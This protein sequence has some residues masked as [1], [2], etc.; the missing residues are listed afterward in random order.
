MHDEFWEEANQRVADFAEKAREG[1]KKYK[2]EDKVQKSRMAKSALVAMK[3][4]VEENFEHLEN[5]DERIK[6]LLQTW[7]DHSHAFK[8]NWWKYTG[9]MG[10]SI[11]NI[12]TTGMDLGW[13]S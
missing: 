1:M 4:P 11:K 2:A 10:W 12:Q 5:L 9:E 13:F 6:N 7:N 3:K 8:D